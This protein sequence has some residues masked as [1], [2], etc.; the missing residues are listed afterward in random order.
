MKPT[1]AVTLLELLVAVILF[2]TIAV[3]FYSIDIFSRNQVLSAQRQIQVQNEVSIALEHI[4]KN[5][6]L[7]IG[8][9]ALPGRAQYPV[10][11]S[12]IGGETGFS[13]YIDGDRNGIWG[14][15]GDYWIAYRYHAATY[16]LWYY[17]NYS[18][19]PSSYE[20][21]ASKISAATFGTT[22]NYIVATIT[23]CWNPAG[24]CGTLQNPQVVMTAHAKMPAVSLM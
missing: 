12:P 22:D 7:A 18:L 24:A 20:I 9:T 23:A 4:T 14:T 6:I 16:E 2:S 8:C 17:P 1:R 15:A 10:D 3:G 5:V 21:V 11:F 19:D 13:V